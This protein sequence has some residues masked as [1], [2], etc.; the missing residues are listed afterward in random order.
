MEDALE[1]ADYLPLSFQSSSEGEYVAFLWQAFEA[2]YQAGQ[3]QFAFLA[4]HMLM[5]SFAYFSIWQIS[6]TLPEDFEKS[7]IG[8]PRDENDLLKA[9][10][11][12]NF[13]RVGESNVFRFLKLLRLDNGKI[14]VYAKL[15]ADR[16]N[17]AHA[18]G[19]I[20]FSDQHSLDG[21]I[22]AVLRAVRE[23][24]AHSTTVI[25]R[26]YEDFLVQSQDE[27]ER[28]YSEPD[29][30][31]REV[32]VRGN[33]MSRKDIEVCLGFDL[34]P[35]Q[36]QTGFDQIKALHQSLQELYGGEGD[37]G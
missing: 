25:R 35:L 18:N 7:L 37:A 36:S 27:E 20:H 24:Q 15:V 28:E 2:N 34:S 30:Q 19:E 21:K 3:Y 29:D 11:P 17:A 1:L 32:L 10:S 6:K 22:A 8:F 31:I 5:M 16:N 23:I 13:S 9:T 26:C 4:C 12:F 14:G 33:Y